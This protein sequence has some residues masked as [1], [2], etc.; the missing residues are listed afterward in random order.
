M[1]EAIAACL[2]DHMELARECARHL[3]RRYEDDPLHVA[4]CGVYNAG[5]SSLLNALAGRSEVFRTGAARVTTDVSKL[6]LEGVAYVDTPGS[7]GAQQDDAIALEG[8][9]RADCVLYAHPLSEVEFQLQERA[10][11]QKLLHRLEDASSRLALVVTKADDTD[12][13]DDEARRYAIESAFREVAGFSPVRTFVVSARR[14]E[15]GMLQRSGIHV[16]KEWIDACAIDADLRR[17]FAR[18]RHDFERG[19]VLSRLREVAAEIEREHDYLTG[20]YAPLIRQFELE[21]TKLVNMVR[22]AMDRI[23]KLPST[24]DSGAASTL[25]ASLVRQAC[26]NAHWGMHLL[27]RDY[28]NLV[29]GSVDSYI[30]LSNLNSVAASDPAARGLDALGPLGVGLRHTPQVQR[31]AVLAN[32]QTQFARLME[33]LG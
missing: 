9:L 14:F 26:G 33:K 15:K 13:S 12:G 27:L 29:Q 16:L 20:K 10:W 32:K 2:A 3:E 28:A 23:R 4:V 8:T 7:D 6:L 21:A 11:L 22:D 24:G 25:R 30:G 1:D 17:S 31:L 5:K 19:E 18:H